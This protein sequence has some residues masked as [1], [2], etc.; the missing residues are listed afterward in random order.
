MRAISE[1][2]K[3]IN[4]VSLLLGAL[5]IILSVFFYL[6]EHKTKEISYFQNGG[7]ALIFDSKSSTPSIKLYET[8]SIPI[9]R[10][11]Y[12]YTGTI[13]NSGDIPIS[14]DDIRIPLSLELDKSSKILDYKILKQKDSIVSKFSL[15][16]IGNNSLKINWKYFDPSYGFVYQIIYQ[17]NSESNLKLSGKV[18]GI[19]SF[20]ILKE[21]EI[22]SSSL[23]NFNNFF[24]L[25]YMLL[26]LFFATKANEGKAMTV[27]YWLAFVF[28]L[29]I[30]RAHV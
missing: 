9:T 10:N 7:T 3:P 15:N 11:V 29:K 20:N 21:E 2:K 27:F 16:K 30:G 17:N 13:W 5:G 22:E 1:F 23:W 8:D 4:F 14:P 24:L 12:L 28:M 19:K 18:L 6:K 25:I 26:M